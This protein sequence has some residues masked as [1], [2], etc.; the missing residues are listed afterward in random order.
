MYNL[1]H[2]LLCLLCI[3]FTA[4]LAFAEAEK[5]DTAPSKTTPTLQLITEQRAYMESLKLEVGIIEQQVKIQ[6]LTDPKPVLMPNQSLIDS[7]S[8]TTEGNS[9]ASTNSSTSPAGNA[10]GTRLLAIHGVDGNAL[11][12]TLSFNGKTVSLKQG[13]NYQGNRVNISRD[14]VT[15][16]SKTFTLE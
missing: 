14:K 5:K 13:Q 3:F 1:K 2:F 15:L 10:G 11:S 16:G 9:A 12:A 4:S 8:V 6:E 7:L